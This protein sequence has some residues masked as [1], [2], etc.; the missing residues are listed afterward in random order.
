MTALSDAFELIDSHPEL[1]DFTGL[2]NDALLH[3]AEVALGHRLTGD[4]RAF[5]D[6]YGAGDVGSQEIYGVF[7]P[8]F[9]PP[10]PPEAIGTTLNA[11]QHGLPPGM[12]VCLDGG[13]G[14]QLVVDYRGGDADAAIVRIMLGGSNDAWE[15]EYGSFADLLLDLVQ[16]ELSSRA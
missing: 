14:T 6:R 9:M 2:P 12:V 5:I 16:R 11:R 8:D 3:D 7:T 13:D 1:T 10:G 4:Y 15:Q